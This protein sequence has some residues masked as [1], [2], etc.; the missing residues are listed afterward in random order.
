MQQASHAACSC[1]RRSHE[2]ACTLAP[3]H[4]WQVPELCSL[5]APC[6][7]GTMLAMACSWLLGQ[8]VCHVV[9]APGGSHGVLLP[10]IPQL[11]PSPCHP[12]SVPRTSGPIHRCVVGVSPLIPQCCCHFMARRGSILCITEQRCMHWAHTHVAS[13]QEEGY[14]EA[15]Q[16]H[17]SAARNCRS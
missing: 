10:P 13:L 6:R 15:A 8:S 1:M 3:G 4:G 11:P 5:H 2:D 7:L 17:R 14:M 9:G 16:C 12:S